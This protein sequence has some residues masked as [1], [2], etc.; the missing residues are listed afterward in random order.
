MSP[1]EVVRCITRF[2]AKPP[3]LSP[4]ASARIFTRP[5]R[6]AFTGRFSCLSEG[7][8]NLV[9][10][11]VLRTDGRMDVARQMGREERGTRIVNS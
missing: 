2:L 1:L 5:L 7:R 9:V 11:L 4:L 6:S 8:V 3:P 10:V